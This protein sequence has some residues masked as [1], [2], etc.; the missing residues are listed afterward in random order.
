VKAPAG[1]AVVLNSR[2]MLSPA[3]PDAERYAHTI[4]GWTH[5]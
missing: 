2:V 3:A 4:P 1:G 5:E